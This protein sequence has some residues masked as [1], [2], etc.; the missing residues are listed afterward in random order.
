MPNTFDAMTFHGD[1]WGETCATRYGTP[2]SWRFDLVASL[3]V[4]FSSD[5]T[6]E[7]GPS[8]SQGHPNDHSEVQRG[9]Q[10]LKGYL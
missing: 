6:P 2:R 8:R 1:A 10:V 9:V 5:A 7:R 3:E 4:L